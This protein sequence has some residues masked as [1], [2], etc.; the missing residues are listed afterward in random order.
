MAFQGAGNFAGVL[1]K[2]DA[3]DVARPWKANVELLT[4]SAGIA[5]EQDHAIGEADGFAH[6]VG[7]EDDC[8]PS[9]LPD[10]LNVAV[11][12]LAG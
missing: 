4:D 5:R 2:L 7:D 12:L 3:V 10:P 8:F 11:K 1:C 6:V 9:L